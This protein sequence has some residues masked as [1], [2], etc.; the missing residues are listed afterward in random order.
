MRQTAAEFV[1]HF[2]DYVQKQNRLSVRKDLQEQAKQ[3][4][5]FPSRVII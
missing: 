2:L 3:D 5:N 4:R 1:P